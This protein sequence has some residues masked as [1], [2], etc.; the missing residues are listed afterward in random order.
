MLVVSSADKVAL[1]L[2][3]TKGSRLRIALTEPTVDRDAFIPDTEGGYCAFATSTAYTWLWPC[4]FERNT[5]HLLS[6]VKFTFGSRR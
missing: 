1:T 6:G 2:K 5:S 4:M 3:P